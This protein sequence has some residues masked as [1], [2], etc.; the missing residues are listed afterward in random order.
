MIGRP[1]GPLTNAAK[2]RAAASCCVP[3]DHRQRLVNRRVQLLGDQRP[4]ARLAA[5]AAAGTLSDSATMATSTLPVSAYCSVC[6]TFSPSTSLGCTASHSPPSASPRARRRR[7]ARGRGWRWRC[8]RSPGRVRSSTRVDLQ[9]AVG[10]RPEGDAAAGVQLLRVGQDQPLLLQLFDVA[11]VGG[12]EQVHR[13]ALLDLLRQLAGGA[14]V[15]DDLVAG[16]RFELLADLAEGVGQV[17]GGRHGERDRRRP[18]RLRGRGLGHNRRRLGQ[19]TR[20]TTPTSR[21]TGM[22]QRQGPFHG[23]PPA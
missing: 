11:D 3:L 7:R 22:S 10:A 13:R 18:A 9:R 12:R 20:P 5:A 17:G 6:R 1:C 4:A 23:S 19:H 2:A 21:I 8:A 15:E 14:E 16:L